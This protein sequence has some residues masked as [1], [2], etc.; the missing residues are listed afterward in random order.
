MNG[1]KMF[2]HE[3]WKSHSFSHL[4]SRSYH[5]LLNDDV[6]FKSHRFQQ[7]RYR[8]YPSFVVNDYFH[9]NRINSVKLRS[10]FRFHPRVSGRSKYPIRDKEIFEI[11]NRIRRHERMLERWKSEGY[12]GIY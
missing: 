2:S 8:C 7:I 10:T 6:Y 12:Y 4:H 9:R 11:H 1:Y 5:S 3:Y